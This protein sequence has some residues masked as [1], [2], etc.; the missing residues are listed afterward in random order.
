MAR[1]EDWVFMDWADMDKDGPL[2]AEQMLF[3]RALEAAAD[4]SSLAGQDGS[5]YAVHA[6]M[7]SKKLDKFFYDEE[8]GAYIDTYASGGGM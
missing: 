1:E 3:I 8:K 4:C 7:L 2:C 5:R 6:E